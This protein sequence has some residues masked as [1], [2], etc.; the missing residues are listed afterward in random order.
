MCYVYVCSL[1]VHARR[2]ASDGRQVGAI[3]G[4]LL[5]FASFLSQKGLVV[6][7]LVAISLHIFQMIPLMLGIFKITFFDGV[8]LKYN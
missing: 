6:W 2:V 5:L 7:W 1:L 8:K 3:V 4:L